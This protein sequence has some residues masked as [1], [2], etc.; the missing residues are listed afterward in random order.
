MSGRTDGW[1]GERSDERTGGRAGRLVGVRAIA[2]VDE[3]W[4]RADW[5]SCGRTGRRSWAGAYDQITCVRHVPAN[6]AV[7]ILQSV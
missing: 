5:A 4:R 1:A 3:R 7:A 6:D 2:L